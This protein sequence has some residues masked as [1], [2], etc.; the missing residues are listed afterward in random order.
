MKKDIYEAGIQ[1]EVKYF[2][3]IRLL[4]RETGS[5]VNKNSIAKTLSLSQPTVEKFL[6]VLA[7]TFHIAIIRPWHTN[8]RKELTK[9]PKAYFYD[10]GMRNAVMRDFSPSADRLDK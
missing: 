7:R 6:F 8:I 1:D 2:S 4:A 3:L 5:L 9:M 10:L